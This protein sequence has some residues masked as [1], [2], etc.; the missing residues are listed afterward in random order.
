ML[1]RRIQREWSA[2]WENRAMRCRPRNATVLNLL[3]VFMIGPAFSQALPSTQAPPAPLPDARTLLR[4]VEAHQRQL[5]KTRENYTFRSIQTIRQLDKKGGLKKL[6]TE[7]REVFFVNRH[8][9]Q[10]LVRKNGKDLTPDEAKKEQERVEKEVQKYTQP[11]QEDKDRDDITVSRLL[12]IVS[13]SNPRRVRL[14]GRSTVVFDFMGDPHAKTHGRNEEALKK[15]SGT[16]WIDE[17][18]REVSRM[19]ATLEDN[20]HVGF[21][22]LASVAKGSNLV[23]DQALV[24]NEVWLPTAIEVHLQAK[25]L[26]VVGVRA[27]VQVRFDQYQKFQADAEQLPGATVVSK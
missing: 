20:Y 26:L 6:E 24:R 5:D 10:R 27:E 22:L 21:G 7:E 16:V 8:R 11:G 15:V 9:I 17:A 1:A 14:N 12:E 13:F 18:D 19:S 2:K 3:L 25:A 4:D 23:F